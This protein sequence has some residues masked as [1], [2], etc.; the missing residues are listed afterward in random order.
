MLSSPKR[1][2]NFPGA[3]HLWMQKNTVTN[4][5]III[6]KTINFKVKYHCPSQLNHKCVQVK[7][8]LITYM[9]VQ[10]GTPDYELK[11]GHFTIE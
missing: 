11:R 8:V 7:E 5:V 10:T 3:F 1:A 9:L 2:K 6:R 4:T